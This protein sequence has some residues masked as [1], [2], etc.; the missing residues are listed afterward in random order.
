MADKLDDKV[1]G[2]LFR[3]KNNEVIPPDEFVVFRPQDNAFPRTLEFYRGECIR[4]G[5]DMAQITALDNLIT[6][7]SQWRKN[8]PSR[9]KLADVEPGECRD[10]P[11]DAYGRSPLTSG[12]EGAVL[13]QIMTNSGASYSTLSEAEAW[14][15]K[16]LQQIADFRAGK[17]VSL[18]SEPVR[19]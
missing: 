13:Q 2:I 9:L 16:T 1:H 11:P 12:D 4:L 10:I 14:C 17:G 6:R 7:V 15:N 19:P 18:S 8:H 3:D 5:C